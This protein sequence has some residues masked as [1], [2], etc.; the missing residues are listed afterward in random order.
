MLF[1]IAMS[2]LSAVAGR[3]RGLFPLPLQ[4][5]GWNIWSRCSLWGRFFVFYAS[6]L[7]KSRPTYVVGVVLVGWLLGVGGHRLV[8]GLQL[9][10][11]LDLNTMYII[12][13]DT[14]GTSESGK[15]SESKRRQDQKGY[16]TVNNRT[17][18]SRWVCLMRIY[19]RIKSS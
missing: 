4:V 2:L 1:V 17:K 12:S 3:F 10:V 11:S 14:R 13:I 7:R 15:Y 9:Q 19:N 18:P 6:T 8:T 5:K 16:M